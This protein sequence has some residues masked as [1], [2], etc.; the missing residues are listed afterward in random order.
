MVSAG[1]NIGYPVG[2]A[3]NH[4]ANGQKP[5][6][7]LLVDSHEMMRT[8]LRLLIEKH[9]GITVVGEA[10]CRDEAVAV[11][12]IE[13]PDITLVNFHLGSQEGFDFIPD[14]HAAARKTRV[15][16]LTGVQDPDIHTR[17]MLLGA[18]GIV[19]KGQSA[20]VLTK[21]LEKVSEG[22]AWIDRTTIANV[23]SEL[24]HRNGSTQIDYDAVKIASLTR[25]E[26]QVVSLACSGLRNKEIGSKLCISVA[27]VRHHMGSIFSKLDVSGRLDL[28]IYANRHGLVDLRGADPGALGNTN[29]RE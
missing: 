12:T 2:A 19:S 15:L 14:L 1:N 28:I 27:T 23:L 11:A 22:E 9:G 20:A 24:S 26:K 3:T 17:A 16:V 13:Q 29:N 21:A 10:A 5:I 25:R 4:E 8:A 18:I 6:R 7:I